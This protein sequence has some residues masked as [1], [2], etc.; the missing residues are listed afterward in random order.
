MLE[1]LKGY[2]T[3]LVLGVAVILGAIDSYNGYCIANAIACKSFAV[4]PIV[5]S[6]LAG[7][8]LYTRSLAGSGK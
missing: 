3:Y 4:P 7:L 2:R 8:G 6:I 5:Y 1:K